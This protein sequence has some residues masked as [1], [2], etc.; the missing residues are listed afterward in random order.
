MRLQLILDTQCNGEYPAGTGQPGSPYLAD[1]INR[2][3]VVRENMQNIGRYYILSDQVVEFGWTPV[4][5]YDGTT[6]N[7]YGMPWR[8]PWSVDVDL[9]KDPIVIEYGQVVND[10]NI[11]TRAVNNIF[12]CGWEQG[13]G[14]ESTSSGSAVGLCF[15][16]FTR[17]YFRDI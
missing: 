10:G 1:T 6:A 3:I 15:F 2:T 4:A 17:A 16:T 11:T 14:D 5:A 13:Q 12:W 8:A 7:V 9:S